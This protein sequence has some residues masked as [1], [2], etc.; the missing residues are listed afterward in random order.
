MC[1]AVLV[2]GREPRRARVVRCG[3]GADPAPSSSTIPAQSTGGSP[4]VAPRLMV[5]MAVPF[6]AGDTV[7]RR[8]VY[9][10]CGGA[11]THRPLCEQLV[12]QYRRHPVLVALAGP[13]SVENEQPVDLGGRER[14][15]D[16]G[17][18]TLSKPGP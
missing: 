16:V 2:D 18:V 6:V 13:S 7:Q 1:A 14:V 15:D 8:V 10:T 4:S 5:S 3:S 17:G 12:A 11:Q 9:E